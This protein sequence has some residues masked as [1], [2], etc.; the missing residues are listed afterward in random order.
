MHQ[1]A[2]FAAMDATP[3]AAP[4]PAGD[5][6]AAHPLLGGALALCAFLHLVFSGLTVGGVLFTLVYQLRGLAVRDYD[7]LARDVAGSLI[8]LMN[9][10]ALTGVVEIMLGT[11]LYPTPF[12]EGNSPIGSVW[13][14]LLPPLAAAFAVT[15]LHKQ[16][17][18]ALARHKGLHVTMIATAAV[19]FLAVQLIYVTGVDS[20]LQGGRQPMRFADAVL[21]PGVL[22]HLLHLVLASLTLSAVFLMRVVGRS[23]FDV[24]GRFRA[25]SRTEIKTQLASVALATLALQVLVGP[26]L[27]VAGAGVHDLRYHL[28]IGLGVLFALP[29]LHWLWKEISVPTRGPGQRH[30]YI[31]GTL[32]LALLF[33]V[34]ARQLTH[35]AHFTPKAPA[36]EA[37]AAAH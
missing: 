12:Y 36:A 10:A 25:L 21:L 31:T 14:L 3:S 6:L 8:A 1:A 18:D 20:A 19:L 17:W 27:Y 16:S 15:W 23:A 28:A 4:L 2:H 24:T 32:A 26:L 11:T 34:V 29:A 13:P 9:L 33:M 37:A 35:A 7:V 22:P 5:V 30:G